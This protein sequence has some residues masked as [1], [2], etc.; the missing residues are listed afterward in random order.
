MRRPRS[1]ARSIVILNRSTI[2]AVNENDVPR[3]PRALQMAVFEPILDRQLGEAK[4]RSTIAAALELGAPV[5]DF[6]SLIL[7]V[8]NLDQQ[9]AAFS[10]LPPAIQDQLVTF[11]TWAEEHRA[12]F[13]APRVAGPDERVA[14]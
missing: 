4:R 14:S 9:W 2:A 11:E 10:D 7:D 13:R 5:L 6:G 12:E 1:G 8:L 3:P